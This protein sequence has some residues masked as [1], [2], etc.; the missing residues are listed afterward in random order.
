MKE[1][2]VQITVNDDVFCAI[3]KQAEADGFIKIAPEVRRL[4]MRG[5]QIESALQDGDRKTIEVP[6]DNFH[7]LSG[8]VQEK[9]LWSVPAFAV[10][11]MAAEMRKH[12]LTPAQ[13]ARAEKSIG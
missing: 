2:R 9:K 8:Y 10:S 1:L 6:V 5:L 12:P 11:A 3:Q 13:K 4:V 7:E